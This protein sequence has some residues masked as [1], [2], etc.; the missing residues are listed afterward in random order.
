M[1]YFEGI[2]EKY[3]AA[4][5]ST[6]VSPQ[7]YLKLE[8]GEFWVDVVAINLQEETL[9]FC[10]VTFSRDV[11]KISRKALSYVENASLYK[12]AIFAHAAIPA[13]WQF[14]PWLF[15]LKDS[16]QKFVARWSHPVRPKITY[17]E[18]TAPW[19]YP[20][21]FRIGEPHKPYPD[22]PPDFQ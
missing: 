8:C 14:R 17:L 10:E 21:G 5:R 2:V 6:F 11:N 3:I 16:A 7:F 4:D 1:D 13:H 15:L 20:N 12:Q 19:F 9:Y 22:L 18:S